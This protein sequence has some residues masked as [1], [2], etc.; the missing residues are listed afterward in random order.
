MLGALNLAG[1]SAGDRFGRRRVARWS[2]VTASISTYPEGS[3]VVAVIDRSACRRRCLYCETDL[4]RH[5]RPQTYFV[6]VC[7]PYIPRGAAELEN[8]KTLTCRNPEIPEEVEE[9]SLRDALTG[10]KL[11]DRRLPRI[12]RRKPRGQALLRFKDRRPRCGAAPRISTT[13]LTADRR[14]LFER[15]LASSAISNSSRRRP[16]PWH[17]M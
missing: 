15:H 7:A 1:G 14:D 12:G 4:S 13:M 6:E 17:W 16:W 2:L 5:P 10:G 8:G 11:R 9:H 3:G